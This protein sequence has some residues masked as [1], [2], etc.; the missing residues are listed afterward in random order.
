VRV[1]SSRGSPVSLRRVCL[2]LLFSAA[3]G[4]STAPVLRTTSG[5]APL[6][7]DPTAGATKV[8]ALFDGRVRLIGAKGP[9]SVKPGAPFQATLYWRVEGDVFGD[10][11]VFVHG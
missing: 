1:I 9:A 4:K 10:P 11:K 2:V 7:A 5:D 8:D 3:C 6:P